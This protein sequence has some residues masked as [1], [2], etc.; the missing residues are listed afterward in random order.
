MSDPTPEEIRKRKDAC[1]TS[2]DKGAHV[3]AEHIMRQMK[4]KVA[5]GIFAIIEEFNRVAPWVIAEAIRDA[6]G[7]EHGWFLADLDDV[8]VQCICDQHGD[9][10]RCI[11]ENG[12]Q[13]RRF[14]FG[15]EAGP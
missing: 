7:A 6:I 3:A 2:P 12:L 15:V 5:L 11:I 4:S 8:G 10:T 9:C 1:T 14:S 13:N